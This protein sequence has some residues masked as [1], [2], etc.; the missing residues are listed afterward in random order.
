ISAD[1]L[2]YPE[3]YYTPP[4]EALQRIEVVRGAASLQY[5]TQFGGMVNFVFREPTK[6]KA[7][8]FISRQTVGSF[9]F[10][11]SFNSLAG[12]ISDGKISYYSFFN[13]RQGSGWRPN[14]DF[15][16]NNGYLNL[17]FRPTK[18]LSLGLETTIM[19]YLAQQPGGLTDA[20]F[21]QN[22]RQSIR[23]RNWFKINWNLFALTLDYSFNDFTRLN[24]RN[25]GLLAQRQS[26]GALTPINNIDFG[27]N[28]TLID[29]MFKNIGSEVRL[30]HRFSLLDLDQT[31]LVG[32]R[33]YRGFSDARQGDGSQ[34]SDP[35]FSFLNPDDLENSDYDFP[36][37][38]MALFAEQII[39]V[40]EHWTIT[41]GIRFE[42]IQTQAEGYFKQRVF[43]AAGN[44]ITENR[45]EESLARNR[46]FLLAGVGVSFKPKQQL[47]L[48][49]NISQNYRAINFTDLRINN[50]N[51]RVDPNIQDER[52]FTADLGFRFRK[53]SQLYLDVTAFHILYRDRIGLLLR[54]DEPP[55]FNDFRLRTNISDAQIYGIEAFAEW[56]IWDFISPE[57]SSRQLTVFVNTAVVDAK[58]INTQDNSVRGRK[59][60]LAPPIMF[61]TGFGWQGGAFRAGGSIAFTSEHFTDATNARRTASAVNGIIPD[62]WVADVSASYKWKKL[63]FELSCNNLLDEAYFTRRADAYPGPGIIP[64]DGRSV[65]L[66]VGIEL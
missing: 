8:Q 5:G 26:L 10:F 45:Q 1:A 39:S 12:T 29:G 54:A 48:Y 14:S 23:Y 58:Y 62:Y 41:P 57:D 32:G 2:G 60:E 46:S 66:T 64:A 16:L 9:G 34:G 65:F 31:L 51:G 15:E 42:Y 36:S 63:T 35:D 28:R 43:D 33:L 59:V 17:D 4:S 50:P 18:K 47:E 38:N 37:Q 49:G 55:L 13:R 53:N 27:G 25:F 11:G 24:I 61:R 44:L 6:D 19:G 21:E 30:L 56:D 20:F 3:S 52:G 7:V 22:P 40:N